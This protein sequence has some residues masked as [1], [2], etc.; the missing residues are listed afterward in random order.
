MGSRAASASAISPPSASRSSAALTLH[1]L[2]PVELA[3]R[4]REKLIYD[5]L[6]SIGFFE[7]F[8]VTLDLEAMRAWVRPRAE[9]AP[10]PAR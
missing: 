10:M 9:P 2:P 6:I 8:V 5:G 7:R 4:L 3:V 1:G